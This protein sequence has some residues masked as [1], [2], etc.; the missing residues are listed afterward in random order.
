MRT[1][2]AKR[3]TK[4]TKG[5]H[6]AQCLRGLALRPDEAAQQL[7]RRT[8]A[9][10]IFN[11]DLSQV[12]PIPMTP[13]ELKEVLK[14]GGLEIY[15]VRG[16]HVFL[17]ER[18]RENLILDAG[19]SVAAA[20]LEVTVT[21]RGEQTH[22]AGATDDTVFTH[23]EALGVPLLRDGFLEVLRRAV[24]MTDPMNAERVLDTFFEISYRKA[25]PGPAEV[26]HTCKRV[27]TFERIAR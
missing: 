13:V 10:S 5:L 16:D 2:V 18:V 27:M 14:S 15:R 4:R 20:T 22:F 21:C 7:W 12:K 8:I 26:V 9:R 6:T 11:A 19:V 23:T 3:L 24:P 1:N 25:L 17:A